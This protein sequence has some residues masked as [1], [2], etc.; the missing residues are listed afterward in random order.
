MEEQRYL[1]SGVLE[2]LKLGAEGNY[3]VFVW[4]LC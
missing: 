3:E 4:V 2:W 1:K